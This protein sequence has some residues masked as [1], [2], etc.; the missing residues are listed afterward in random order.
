M[1]PT[2]H[3]RT[4]KGPCTDNAAEAARETERASTLMLH[5][6]CGRPQAKQAARISRMG[7]GALLLLTVLASCTRLASY[8][9]KEATGFTLS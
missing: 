8:Q 5:I 6:A 2:G 9:T 7:H 4:S 1:Q 3:A